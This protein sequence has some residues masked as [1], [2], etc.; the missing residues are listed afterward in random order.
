MFFSCEMP[1]KFK[2]LDISHII[3]GAIDLTALQLQDKK[4]KIVLQKENED[5]FIHGDELQLNQVILNLILNAMYASPIGR[6]IYV[7]IRKVESQVIVDIKDEGEGVSEENA[8]KI[9]EPFF[10]TKKGGTG[11]GLAVVH[12]IMQQHKAEI[13]L[14]PTT[15]KGAHFQL[16]FPAANAVTKN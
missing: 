6:N 15:E 7:D 12:G 4:L 8:T 1:F 11:L 9:F 2:T 10:T 13:K 16:I 3:Q 14:I 5:T